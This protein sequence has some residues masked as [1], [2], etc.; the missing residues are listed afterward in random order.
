MLTLDVL[1]DRC[2][3][4]TVGGDGGGLDDLLGLAVIGRERVTRRWLLWGHAWAHPIVLERRKEIA[5]ILLDFA[6]AGE[7]TIVEELGQDVTGFCDV[8]ERIDASGKLPEKHAIG[9]DPVGIGQIVDELAAR[10][11]APEGTDRIAGISQGWK[12]SGAIKTMERKL[13]DGTLLHSGSGLMAWCVANAKVEPR[14][15]AVMITKQAA[16]VAKIDLLMAAFNAAA[17]MALNPTGA[18]SYELYFA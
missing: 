18:R 8:V 12:L 3:V 7:L 9:L 5:P 10:G 13:A 6:K 1:L 16:G 14:G 4:A 17:L 15:N 11:I 2:D